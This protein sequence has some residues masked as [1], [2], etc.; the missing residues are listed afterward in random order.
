[1]DTPILQFRPAP[2]SEEQRAKILQPRDVA[3]A[4]RFVAL[5][6]KHVS[7]PELVIKPTAQMYV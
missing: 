3:E 4:V 6:P 5:L 1:M 2:L 7:V